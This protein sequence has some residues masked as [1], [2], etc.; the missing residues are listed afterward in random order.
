MIPP[1]FD[2]TQTTRLQRAVKMHDVPTERWPTVVRRTIT[3]TV[4]IAFGVAGGAV[5]AFPWYASAGL[6][7]LGATVWSTKLVTSSL[8]ALIEPV[9]AIRRMKDGE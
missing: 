7:L 4:L 9:Q 1:K 3:G 6:V 2:P 5:L 8:K